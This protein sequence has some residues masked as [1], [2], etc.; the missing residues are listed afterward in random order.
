MTDAFSYRVKFRDIRVKP[1]ADETSRQ[2]AAR[3]RTCEHKG[4]DLA[5]DHPAPQPGGEGQFWF[6]Q[7]H[8]AEYNRN[9]NFFDSMTEAEIAAFMDAARH[10]HKQ[11]WRFGTGPMGA[12]K[13]ANAHNPRFWRGRDLFEDGMAGRSA[14][15]P[16]EARGRTRLQVRALGELDLAENATPAEIRQ[17][18][19]EYIRRFHPDSNGGDRSSEH[20]L[21]RVL[22]A[23]RTLKQAGLMK[24]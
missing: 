21:S 5:G 18:Y 16:A 15:Q 3:T 8:A 14:P 17:R 24:D 13:A 1:P 9:Y 7:R 10:G 23:G 22:R 4:C 20:K 12:G 2:R 6:C 11:T 19:A